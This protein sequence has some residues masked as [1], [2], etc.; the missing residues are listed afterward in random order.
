MH[1]YMMIY[2]RHVHP[3]AMNAAGDGLHVDGKLGT[4]AVCESCSRCS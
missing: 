2:M 4:V 3:G 1:L